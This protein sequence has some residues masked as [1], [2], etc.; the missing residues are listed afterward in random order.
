MVARING[1]F[2]TPVVPSE[3]KSTGAN[4]SPPKESSFAKILGA[5]QAQLSKLKFSAHAQQRMRSRSLTLST[6]QLNQISEA[7]DKASA[8]GAK[9][10]L[11]LMKDMAF[12]VS[13][14][15]RTVIT[16]I[17]GANVKDNVFTRIDSAVLL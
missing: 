13:V 7:V 9:N 6:G 11:V 8:K 12:I 2:F 16:A 5:R 15:N 10:S 4:G 1:R 14:E 17:D 3:S